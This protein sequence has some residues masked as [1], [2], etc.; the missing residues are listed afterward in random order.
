MSNTSDNVRVFGGSTGF[1][2]VAPS[3][4]TL[5]TDATTGLDSAFDELGYIDENG[6][7][8]SQGTNTNKVKAWQG[9]AIVRTVQ[10]EHSLTYKFAALETNAAVLEQFYGQSVYDGVVEITGAQPDTAAWV[11]HAVDGDDLVRIVIPSGQVIDRGDVVR[12][13]NDPA[14]YE[15]TLECY[16]DSSGVKAYQYL[17]GPDS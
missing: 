10:T 16:P 6:V 13:G 3:G 8:E 14:V 15:F 11:I 4:S 5:P 9:G 12:N 7:T 1:V 2:A 17:S